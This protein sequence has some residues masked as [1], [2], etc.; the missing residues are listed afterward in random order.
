M[1]LPMKASEASIVAKLRQYWVLTKSLQTGLLLVT[2]IAGYLSARCPFTRG[3]TLLAVTASL[4][5]AIAGSTV[6]NMVWDR[7]IDAVMRR[8]CA[9]PL[10]VGKVSAREGAA[11][12]IAMSVVGIAW[13]S[14]LAPLYGVIVFAGWFCDVVIYTMWLK[15]RTPWSIL[16][17][18]IAGAMPILAGRALGTGTIDAIGIL[19]A[20]AIL[21]WIPTHMLTFGIKYAEQYRAAGVPVFPNAYGERLTR[22]AIAGATSAAVI[23]MVLAAWHIRLPWTYFHLALWLGI[24]LVAFT[25]VSIARQSPELNFGLYKFASLYMLGAMALIMLGATGG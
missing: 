18:G 23:A 24:A 3:E 22:V 11:L 5:L 4:F 8:T 14:A 25:F 10:P 9:R 7:D 13:A 21:L 1:R 20:L 16:W 17:G 12:G 15:R 2:G 19:L 6:L